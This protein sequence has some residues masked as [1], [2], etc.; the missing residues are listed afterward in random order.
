MDSTAASVSTSSHEVDELITTLRAWGIPYLVGLESDHR[1]SIAGPSMKNPQQ[2]VIFLQRLAQ[3][4][5]YPRVRDAIISLLLL[6]PEL[7]SAK[8]K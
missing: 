7:A 8:K 2:V 4:N 6:H 5:D 1:A 3:C